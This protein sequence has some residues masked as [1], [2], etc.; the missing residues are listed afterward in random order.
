M[1]YNHTIAAYIEFHVITSSRRALQTFANI[2]TSPENAAY[3]IFL[4]TSD[5]NLPVA[6][7]KRIKMAYIY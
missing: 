5:S 6:F 2:E 7:L 1:E 4:V 3:E